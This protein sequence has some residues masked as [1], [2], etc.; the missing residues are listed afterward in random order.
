M[1][2]SKENKLNI[3]IIITCVLMLHNRF[4]FWVKKYKNGVS[5]YRIGI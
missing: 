5:R 2:K 4:K 3:E 1:C